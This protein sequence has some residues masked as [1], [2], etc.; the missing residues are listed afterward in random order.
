MLR[1]LLLL[2]SSVA[3]GCG[4]A[5]AP[6]QQQRQAPIANTAGADPDG[7][8]CELGWLPRIDQ[9]IVTESSNGPFGSFEFRAE[10]AG[11]GPQ[12][13]GTARGAYRRFPESP[14]RTISTELRVSRDLLGYLL[15]GIARG[16]R[17][18]DT[19]SLPGRVVATDTSESRSIRIEAEARVGGVVHRARLETDHGEDEPQP[20]T[21]VG[22]ERALSHEAWVRISQEY[23]RIATLVR[24]SQTLIDLYKLRP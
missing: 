3:A 9:L 12:L 15:A 20:W 14:R 5:L 6:P 4:S 2:S 23:A 17:I 1:V 19:T 11:H 16:V 24:R 21:V 13:T 7:A 10:L 8:P 22:C 18:P